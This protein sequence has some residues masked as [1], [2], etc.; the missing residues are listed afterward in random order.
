MTWKL[1][2]VR[3][4]RRLY[5]PDPFSRILCENTVTT[6]PDPERGAA[7]LG[8]PPNRREFSPAPARC[9]LST[10]AK[11]QMDDG[12]PTRRSWASAPFTR[13]YRPK[14][15]AW[16]SWCARSSSVRAE[17]RDPWSATASRL[18]CWRLLRSNAEALGARSGTQQ[19]LA[20]PRAH[21]TQAAAEQNELLELTSG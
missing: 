4:H 21:W 18:R 1:T 19:V 17:A 16:S 3:L 11:A 15:R 20:A 7:A 12:R 10:A 2:S 8:C 9:S 13:H 14:R 5:E 6:S